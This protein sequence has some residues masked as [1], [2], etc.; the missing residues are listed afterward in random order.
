MKQRFTAKKIAFAAA[1]LALAVIMSLIRVYTLPMGGEVTL[2][3]MLFV[4]LIGYC[5]GPWLGIGG[6][7]IYGLLQFIINPFFYS[8]PQFIC[9]YILAFGCLGLSG[10]FASKKHGLKTGYLAAIAGRFI[11]SFLSGIIFFADYAQG[12][13]HGAVVYSILYN[14]SYIGVEGLATMI[15]LFI[16]PVD[17]ALKRIKKTAL[18]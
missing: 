15:V 9:D 13:G 2:F 5:F 11:F 6:S 4:T 18:I 17:S 3:S 1:A 14:G 10:F 12:S 16:P 8:F 7:I